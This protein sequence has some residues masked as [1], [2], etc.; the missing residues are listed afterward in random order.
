MK[1]VNKG[2]RVTCSDHGFSPLLACADMVG[3]FQ[4]CRDECT[5]RPSEGGEMMKVSG[6]YMCVCTNSQGEVTF[7]GEVDNSDACTTQCESLRSINKGSADPMRGVTGDWG[8][9]S[10]Q[11]AETPFASA[12]GDEGEVYEEDIIS[13][14]PWWAGALVGLLG[15]LKKY[16]T[17]TC[18]NPA[19]GTTMVINDCPIIRKCSKC[20]ES[21]WA[22]WIGEEVVQ[23]RR[24]TR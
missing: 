19:D 11:C 24:P 17:C 2:Y 7:S 5:E 15:G 22:G 16:K 18:T 12:T 6:A 21:R 20:C 14:P 23:G 9:I 4:E 13:D 8:G 10:F 3:T 1:K